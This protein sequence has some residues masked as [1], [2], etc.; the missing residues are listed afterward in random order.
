MGNTVMSI[1]IESMMT[2]ID[3]SSQPSGIY[4]IQIIDDKNT[5]M[6]KIIKN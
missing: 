4:Y 2:E 6:C 5:R 3:I 1:E